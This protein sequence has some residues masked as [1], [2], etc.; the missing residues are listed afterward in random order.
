MFDL[1]IPIQLSLYGKKRRHSI[2]IMN[3][4]NFILSCLPG[5]LYLSK[6]LIM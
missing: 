6:A 2:T 4:G 1:K 3:D 5:L